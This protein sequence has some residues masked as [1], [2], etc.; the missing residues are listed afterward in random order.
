[1]RRRVS[2]LSVPAVAIA[3]LASVTTGGSWQMI[4]LAREHSRLVRELVALQERAAPDAREDRAAGVT[5]V[6]RVNAEI[7]QELTRLAD[8]QAQTAAAKEALPPMNGQVLHSL[9]RIEDLGR[10]AGRFIDQLVEFSNGVGS[11]STPKRSEEETMRAMQSMMSWTAWIEMIGD[12]EDDPK[13]IARLHATTIAE[14]L[15]LDATTAASIEKQIAREFAELAA[16]G[17]VRSKRP[18][19]DKLAAWRERR[20]D[21][22]HAA[23]ARVES[24]IPA[25]Q[26]QPWVVEQSL[27]LGNALV[28]DVEM[29]ADGHGSIAIGVALPGV[30]MNF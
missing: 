30:K 9:G 19:G 23:A 18:S 12:M 25:D 3:V 29:G 21:T 26:R 1:M 5:Q 13:E 4:R 20:D 10:Q 28:R 14:R 7:E 6:A 11:P 22:L 15:K 8:A 17:L 27:Q 24:Q 16:A 2:S